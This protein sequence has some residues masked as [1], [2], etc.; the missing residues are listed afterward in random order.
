VPIADIGTGGKEVVLPNYSKISLSRD[1][2]ILT[3]YSQFVRLHHAVRKRKE[4]HD[5]EVKVTGRGRLP[6]KGGYQ[7]DKTE[8]R[9][10]EL[11]EDG[12]AGEGYRPA[13]RSRGVFSV[14]SLRASFSSG[15]FIPLPCGV[16]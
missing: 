9:E 2:C 10:E 11:Q 4:W 14:G 12:D 15:V 7:E 3:A 8:D 1:T 5:K 16:F 6:N 13:A